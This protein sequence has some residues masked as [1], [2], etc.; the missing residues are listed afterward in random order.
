[1]YQEQLRFVTKRPTYPSAQ[2]QFEL[3]FGAI[4]LRGLS[5]LR[6]EGEHSDAE[7]GGPAIAPPTTGTAGQREPA[8]SPRG[9]TGSSAAGVHVRAFK[10]RELEVNDTL[11]FFM[12]PSPLL[13]EWDTVSYSLC[14]HFQ[15]YAS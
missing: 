14:F 12:V 3:L 5:Q 7:L 2:V 9:L 11:F 6:D 1:M 4:F 8:R 13:L 15:G 10:D